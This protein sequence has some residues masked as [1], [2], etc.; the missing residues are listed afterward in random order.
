MLELETKHEQCTICKHEYTSIN[1]EVMPGIK[2]Y[3]CDTC[4]EAAKYHFI[5]VC[6]SCGQVYLR[7]KKLV[8][9]RVKDAELKKAYMLCE[10]MQI[11]QGID[12]CIACDP[13]G[14]VNYMDAQKT[15]TC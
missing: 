10:D 9:E 1:T 8:I 6:M 4:L 5:F 2:I 11:I 13:E 7:P 15:A 3:V 14:I 12:M